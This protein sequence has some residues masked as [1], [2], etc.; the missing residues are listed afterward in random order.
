MSLSKF[1]KIR[2]G[3]FMI[4]EEATENL[5]MEEIKKRAEKELKEKKELELNEPKIT[6]PV[7]EPTLD[8]TKDFS[9]QAKDFVGV[10]ATAKAIKDDNLVKKVTEHK[11]EELE[12]KAD[13]DKKIEK[14]KNKRAETDLQ[15]SLFGVYEGVASYAGIKRALPQKM[16]TAIMWVLQPVIGILLIVFG[17]IAGTINV[18]MDAVNSIVEKFATFAEHT[19]RIIK[20]LLWIAITFGFVWILRGILAHFGIVIF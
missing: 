19:Q 5:T 7:L 17:L 9:E 2:G 16:L 18:I 10:L 15:N 3:W 13:A 4:N 6:V 14:A 1:K 20:A 8:K 12:S 11:I